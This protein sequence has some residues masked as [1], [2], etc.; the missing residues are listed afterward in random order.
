[1]KGIKAEQKLVQETLPTEK[2]LEQELEKVLELRDQYKKIA[3]EKGLKGKKKEEF[4][5]E[6]LMKNG[7]GKIA[8]IPLARGWNGEMPTKEE[9]DKIAVEYIKRKGWS[10]E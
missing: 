3:A 1:M 2:E 4:V 6:H 7:V 8:A 10:L 9:R 5:V